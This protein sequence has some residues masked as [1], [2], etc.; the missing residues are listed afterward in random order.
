[1]ARLPPDTQNHHFQNGLK[2]DIR[3]RTHKLIS[4][5]PLNPNKY[6]DYKKAAYLAER[7]LKEEQ[8]T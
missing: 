3:K 5:L 4:D 7:E 8:A 1:L 6:E 2:E